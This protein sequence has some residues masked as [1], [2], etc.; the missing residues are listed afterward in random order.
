MSPTWLDYV[1]PTIDRPEWLAWRRGGVGASDVATILNMNPFS[2]PAALYLDKVGLLD[3]GDMTEAQFWGLRH[4]PTIAQVFEERTGLFVRHAQQCV[5]DSEHPQRRCTLDGL[6]YESPSPQDRADS[7]GPLQIKTSRERPFEL[8]PDHYAIQVQFE[9]GVTGFT[10][11]WLAVLH[12]GNQLRLYE[13]EF[14]PSMFATLSRSVDRFWADNV[15]AKNPPPA[16]GSDATTEALKN[17]YRDRWKDETLELEGAEIDLAREWLAAD[18]A[19]KEA[20][21]WA[22]RCKNQL[23]SILGENVVGADGDG[24]ELL[25][26]KSQ[27]T[28]ARIDTKALRAA[29]PEIVAEF[30]QPAGTTRVLRSTKALKAL[31]GA[32]T[33]GAHE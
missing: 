33:E 26:W 3:D 29:H 7:L 32:Q 27:R 15:L 22:D 19:L 11:E 17:A 18:H 12:G 2:S 31:S 10:Q 25:T 8:V 4:E 21:T 30:T 20:Q 23:C 6:V 14:D 1:D 24:E 13:I 16:D 28:G 5:Q 9:M